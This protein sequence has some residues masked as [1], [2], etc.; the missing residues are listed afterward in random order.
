M[1]CW[2]YY[3]FYVVAG[4]LIGFLVTVCCRMKLREAK[5]NVGACCECGK[6]ACKRRA[7]ESDSDEDEGAHLL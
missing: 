2:G 5:A 1:P 4:L 3:M 7:Y 6:S